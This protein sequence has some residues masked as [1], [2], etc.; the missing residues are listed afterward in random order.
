MD[1]VACIKGVIAEFK[2]RAEG[3]RSD[4]RFNGPGVATGGWDQLRVEQVVE[5]L[6]ENAIKHGES[7]IDVSIDLGEHLKSGQW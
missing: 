2:E 5:T 3:R 7:P 4:I 1:L 6:I